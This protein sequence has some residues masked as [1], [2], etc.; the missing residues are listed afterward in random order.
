MGNAQAM[1][2]C[3]YALFQQ[4][5][6]GPLCPD[7]TQI[8]EGTAT[9]VQ[10]GG[11][12]QRVYNLVSGPGTPARFGI[13]TRGGTYAVPVY[14]FQTVT[15][16]AHAADNY[17]VTTEVANIDSTLPIVADDLTLWG[18]P[19]DHNGSAPRLPFLSNPTDCSTVPVTAL[20]L[21]N[22]LNVGEFATAFS[23]SPKPT[24]CQDVPFDPS[25]SLSPDT[26]RAGAPAGLSVDLALPQNQDPD[27]RSTSALKK[28]VVTLP[29]GMVLSPSAAGGLDGCT[30]A[31]I[32]LKSDAPGS[33]PE[34]SKIG[35]VQ[36][37]SPLLGPDFGGTGEGSLTGAAYLGKPESGPITAPPYALYLEVA[38]HGLDVKLPGTVVPDPVTGRLTATFDENP[39]LPFDHFRL[40]FKGGPRAALSNPLTC[41]RQTTTTQLTPYS[42]PTEPATPSSSFT[43]SWDGQ[44]APCPV[45]LPFNPG[46]QAGVQNPSAVSSSPF[47][48]HLTRGDQEQTFG[49]VSDVHLPLGLLASIHGIPR[50]PDAQAAAGS[51]DPASQIGSVATGAGAGPNPFYLAGRV[52]LTDGYK[53]APFGLAIVVPAV[54][55]PFDLGNVVVRAALFVDPATT[56]VTVQAD[57]LPT[58]LQGVPL[59]VR[60]IT[61]SIDRP[62]FMRNPSSCDPMAITANAVSLQGTVAPLSNRFQVGG[63]SA[64]PFKPSFKASTAGVTSKLN[65]ASLDVSVSQ[66]PGEGDIKK[67]DVQLPRVLP[68]RLSTL[69]KACTSGQF[70]A[71]PAGCP[72][73][74]VVGTAT[75]TTPLLNAPLT[76][77]AYLVSHGGAAFPDLVLVLQGEGVRIDLTGNTQITNGVTF[78]HFETVPDAPISSFELKLPQGP[79]SVLAAIKDL[80]VPTRMVTVTKRVALRSHRH[81]VRRHGHT[82]YVLRKIQRSVPDPLVMPTTITAQDGAVVQQNT[83]IQV[84]GCPTA[85]ASAK[86]A[87]KATKAKRA[88]R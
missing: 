6:G 1:P 64:L 31:Q 56:A 17:A 46:F 45:S 68:S 79:Y 35:T 66:A 36:V 57:P 39:Q 75:A 38:G 30:P 69:Q 9:S 32:A 65:G 25:I 16:A 59:N 28:A 58:I 70:Q 44:G 8:G 62:G 48:F 19:A 82:V 42:A 80:C 43:T 87:K 60:D 23:A 84:T 41:G 37:T 3:P 76:G 2:A 15:V 13:S 52:Y 78:S 81:I 61:L 4:P 5:E 7:D 51:C 33:C 11:L 12:P 27:G 54:A 29:E 77:P 67:V 20:S 85:K 34:A 40:Q 63:C 24:N 10:G 72:A 14:A 26:T 74:S 47:V 49:Q 88:H 50:C 86:S 18:V 22:L 53:G 21:D 71:D 83:N 73:G 55:G